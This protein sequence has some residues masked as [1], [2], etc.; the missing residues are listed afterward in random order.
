MHALV[1]LQH[2]IAV[3]HVPVAFEVVVSA[4]CIEDRNISTS[5]LAEN[6]KSAVRMGAATS[7]VRCNGKDCSSA[8]FR[9]RHG[10]HRKRLKE[11]GAMLA[12][13]I[14]QRWQQNGLL[15]RRKCR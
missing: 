3:T 1:I 6:Q 9:E 12:G 4:C 5:L 7:R 11:I 14:L 15:R 8:F 2:D 10:K 13:R